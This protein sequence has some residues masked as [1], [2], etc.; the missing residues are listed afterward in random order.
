MQGT[1]LN[2]LRV[3]AGERRPRFMRHVRATCGLAQPD[4]IRIVRSAQAYSP[5]LRAAAL[6][7][8][9]AATPIEVTRGR[10]YVGRWRLVRMH[11]RL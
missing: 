7:N 4:L 9:V 10:C 2:E 11:Y 3:L 1:S 8:L 6:R 5:L